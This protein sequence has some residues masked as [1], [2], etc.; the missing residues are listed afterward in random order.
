M[1]EIIVEFPKKRKTKNID[2]KF[3]YK[4]TSNCVS[5]LL[6]SLVAALA[7][8]N[9]IYSKKK[10]EMMNEMLFFLVDE[11]LLEFVD[12]VVHH[13]HHLIVHLFHQFVYL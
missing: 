10:L 12:R 1:Y 9:S 2:L 11:I 13:Q 6:I 3:S 8:S 5:R 4:F 7:R